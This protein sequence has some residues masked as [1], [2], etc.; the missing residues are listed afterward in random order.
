MV[1]KKVFVQRTPEGASWSPATV[2]KENIV[3]DAEC[4]EEQD[5]NVCLQF[6][7][8]ALVRPL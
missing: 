6:R 2:L 1:N 8:L 7:L 3:A 4:M 5:T